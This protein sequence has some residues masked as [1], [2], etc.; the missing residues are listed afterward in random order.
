MSE[1]MSEVMI[2]ST[3]DSKAICQTSEQKP[4]REIAPDS[5]A[6]SF[7]I[8]PI[9]FVESIFVEKFAVPRQGVLVKNARSL[10]KLTGAYNRQEAVRGLLAYS[11]LWLVGYFHENL[12]K[13]SN[14]LLVRPPKL[15]GNQKIGVFAS[16][17]PFRPN[18]LG[19]SL[20]KLEGVEVRNKQVCILVSGCD[21]IEGTPIIDI[22]PY[23]AY[24]DF[25]DESVSLGYATAPL[26][27][28]DEHASMLAAPDQARQRALEAALISDSPE[29]NP[30]IKWQEEHLA[31]VY[32][33][34]GT[35]L[36]AGYFANKSRKRSPESNELLELIQDIIWG[37]PAPGYHQKKLVASPKSSQPQA[38]KAT[39]NKP[40]EYGF[41]LRGINVRFCY[42][43]TTPVVTEVKLV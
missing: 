28:V 15:G 16:R 38:A 14:Q 33:H 27:W 29:A 10:I 11:H 4:H 12:S 20:V 8:E 18:N 24:A 13:N 37:Q 25:P 34:N 30:A 41:T 6:V 21:Y 3:I 43:E 19:L 23:L 22:K 35:L 31:L 9:G 40:R 2:E 39:Q 42:Q 7:R 36:R 5:K 1:V 17:A 26:T 32:R